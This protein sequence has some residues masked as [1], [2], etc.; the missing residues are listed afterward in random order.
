MH[1]APFVAAVLRDRAVCELVAENERLRADN[2]RLRD[3][4]RRLRD[5]GNALTF[6]VTRPD[7]VPVLVASTI[8]VRGVMLY[9]DSDD[10]RDYL[11][12]VVDE[13]AAPCRLDL[14]VPYVR[15]RLE[16][17]KEGG[18]DPHMVSMENFGYYSCSVRRQDRG[19]EMRIIFYEGYLFG[20]LLLHLCSKGCAWT[21][22]SSPTSLRITGTRPNPARWSPSLTTKMRAVPTWTT[23][24]ERGGRFVGLFSRRW[25]LA[26]QAHKSSH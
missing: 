25:T 17:K 3:D 10:E 2:V 1:L 19:L 23:A 18:L 24:N 12:L 21:G 4:V 16:L 5:R 9:S 26:P 22:P 20:G 14:L 15:C 8:S 13:D 11:P 7:G 6:R